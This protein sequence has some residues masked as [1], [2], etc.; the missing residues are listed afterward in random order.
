MKVIIVDKITRFTTKQINEL[1]KLGDLTFTPMNRSSL[2]SLPKTVYE[3]EVIL[4]P[5]PEIFNWE[6]RNE[7]LRRFKNLKAICLPTT[8]FEML[9][10]EYCKRNEINVTN[11]PNYSTEA[12]AEYAIWMMLSLVRKLPL[13]V[14][15]KIDMFN[16]T[17]VQ[18][19]TRGKVMG[20]I[21]LGNIGQRIAEYGDRMGMKVIYWSRSKKDTFNQRVT[22]K[23]LVQTADYIFPCYEIN[24]KT[25]NLLDRQL[26]SLL[27]NT[28]YLISINGT[29]GFDATFAIRQVRK[30]KLAGVAYEASK[31]KKVANTVNIFSPPPVAWYTKEAQDRC[32]EILTETIISV[33]KGNPHNLVFEY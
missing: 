7:E 1:K 21:G 8:S 20:I 3:K 27:K 31:H 14:A 4:V 26:L 6:I 12:V 22:L 11:T 25:K 30:K 23:K 9:D 2:S 15:G 19:E 18:E 16:D 5:D 17:L 10:M 33:I 13:M 29:K 32:Y 24:E 28:S